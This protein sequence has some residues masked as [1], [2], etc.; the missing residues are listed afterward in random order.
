M[1][2]KEDY[3]ISCPYSVSLGDTL[4]AA[5]MWPFFFGWGLI[6]IY[7]SDIGVSKFP[8]WNWDFFFNPSPL[9]GTLS[10][11]CP[12]LSYDDSPEAKHIYNLLCRDYTWEIIARDIL[13]SKQHIAL[14][15]MCVVLECVFKKIKDHEAVE[16]YQIGVI[17][18]RMSLSLV[19]VSS[20]NRIRIVQKGIWVLIN[21]IRILDFCIRF[22]QIDD[23]YQIIC[24]IQISGFFNR[25]LTDLLG[26]AK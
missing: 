14:S 22:N 2:S 15:I 3:M 19:F 23:F 21:R 12:F 8:N 4:T 13:D 5:A 9:L 10:Q 24:L 18:N 11:I 16:V 6:V 1:T 26:W 7:N 25:I 20:F 17:R